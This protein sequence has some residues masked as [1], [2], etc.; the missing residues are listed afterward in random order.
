M[1]LYGI[2]LNVV[3]DDEWT[4]VTFGSISG[5]YDPLTRTISVPEKIYIDACAGVRDALFIMMHEIG[6]LILGHQASLH[7]SKTPPTFAEDAEWQ[8]DK[9]AEYAL[10]YLGYEEEKQLA[11]D[12]Y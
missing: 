9:F 4:S 7:Y 5:H 6:H 2:T 1:S 12:F 10:Y 8:A 11:F 3:A